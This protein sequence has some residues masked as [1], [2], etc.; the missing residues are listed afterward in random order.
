M[1]ANSDKIEGGRWQCN[2]CLKITAHGGNMKQHFIS[3]HY[4]AVT[5]SP[6]PFCGRTFKNKNSLASHVSQN[7]KE[8]KSRLKSGQW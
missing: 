8:E 5:E 2:I 4:E 6:C 1:R 7:H 3:H